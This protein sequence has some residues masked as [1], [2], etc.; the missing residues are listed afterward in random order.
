MSAPLEPLR[1][2]A[3]ILQVAEM[4]ETLLEMHI[5]RPHRAMALFRDD[6]LGLVLGSLKL[7]KLGVILDVELLLALPQVAF[8][9]LLAEVIFLA[10][11]EQ[12]DIGIL[13]DRT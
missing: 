8:R 13:L 11:D 7:G 9:L 1:N 12:H 5:D 10:I 6:H 2:L 3:L 4:G